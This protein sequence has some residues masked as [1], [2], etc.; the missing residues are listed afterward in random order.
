MRPPS[1]TYRKHVASMAGDSLFVAGVKKD[2]RKGQNIRDG[3]NTPF[4]AALMETLEDL[5]RDLWMQLGGVNPVRFFE[6]IRIRAELSAIQF[7][8]AKL[9]SHVD[10]AELLYEEMKR[11]EE[12]YD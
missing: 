4:G 1:M 6:H 2:I 12:N 7:I 10:N 5:E 3:M 11:M 8:K 9:L